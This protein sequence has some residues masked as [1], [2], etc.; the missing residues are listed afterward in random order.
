MSELYRDDGGGEVRDAGT[1][2]R[3][4]RD[5]RSCTAVSAG[6]FDRRAAVARIL[7][8]RTDALVV[9]GLGAATYDV[10][11]AGDH[12]RN[13]YLWGAMG[14][15]AMV[16]LGL[17]LARPALPVIVITGDGEM[18]MG[19]GA[20]ATIGLQ[21]PA[22][23]TVIVL[24]N[25]VYG[26]TGGQPS[27]TSRTDLAAVALACGFPRAVTVERDEALADLA[28]RAHRV[29]GGPELAVVRVAV[30][31][32]P[33]GVPLREGAHN[34]VRLRAALGLPAD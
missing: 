1:Y 8:G 29:G 18:L 10:A 25:G 23:L 13:F 4:S 17:A 26:E 33:R 31:S 28:V 34:K 7:A 3:R 11:A 32:A 21:A 12:D 14:G 19:M 20:L 22:N 6:R 30:A 15:A 24:D 2:H 5:G 16:G 27:H 9:S